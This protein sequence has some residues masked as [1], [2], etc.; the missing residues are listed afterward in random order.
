[1]RQL[2]CIRCS[3]V[4]SVVNALDD[5]SALDSGTY[6]FHLTVDGTEST[7]DARYKWLIVNRHSSVLSAAS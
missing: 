3:L 4:I 5:N 2:T 1:M 6:R 7:V